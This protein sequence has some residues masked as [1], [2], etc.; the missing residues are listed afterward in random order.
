QAGNYKITVSDR[1]LYLGLHEGGIAEQVK[2]I[3]THA[4]IIGAFGKAEISKLNAFDGEVGNFLLIVGRG[5]GTS[6]GKWVEAFPDI[7]RSINPGLTAVIGMIVGKVNNVAALVGQGLRK[8][9]RCI[10]GWVTTNRYVTI[11]RCF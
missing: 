4:L 9:R 11:T 10:K 1:R 5:I 6:Q 8:T 7:E 3:I 2:S